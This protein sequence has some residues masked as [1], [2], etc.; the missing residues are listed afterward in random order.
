MLSGIFVGYKQHHGGGWTG[1]L[2]IID[3]IQMENAERHSDVYVKTF[4]SSE[5]H[6]VKL[7][8]K[9]RFPC[10]TGDLRQPGVDPITARLRGRTVHSGN[11]F[12]GKREEKINPQATEDDPEQP[13][14]IQDGTC[15]KAPQLTPLQKYEL[16][17]N[18]ITDINQDY[19]S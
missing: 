8:D 12:N 14:P 10:S 5:I 4:K 19:G 11:P 15:N 2:R 17:E 13:V 9:F 16:E 18:H 3:W 7:H 1:D 6:P